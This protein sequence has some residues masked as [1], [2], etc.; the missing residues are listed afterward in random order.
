MRKI[1]VLTAVALIMGYTAQ[2]QQ[3]V[4]PRSQAE[5]TQGY[6]SPK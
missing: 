2:A 6:M 5:D 1:I 4:F 3:L